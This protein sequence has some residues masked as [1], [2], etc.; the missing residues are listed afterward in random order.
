MEKAAAKE[1]SLLKA[2][3]EGEREKAAERKARLL[4]DQRKELEKAAAK[5]ASLLKAELAGERKA[6]REARLLEAQRKELEKAAAK[7]ASLLKAE[8]ARLL[9]DRLR[10]LRILAS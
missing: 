9:G 5:E 1:A 4:E 3:L 8:F 6:E 2:E 7:E 10:R